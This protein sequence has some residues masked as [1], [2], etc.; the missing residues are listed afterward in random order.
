M[1]Q[2]KRICKVQ[3]E[4]SE[5]AIW[6]LTIWF[7]ASKWWWISISR[8]GFSGLI[9]PDAQC[10]GYLPAFT[11]KTTQMYV[12]RPYIDGIDNTKIKTRNKSMLRG[13]HDPEPS[14][15][16]SAPAKWLSL[17]TRKS[18]TYPIGS[19]GLVLFTYI[20]HQNQLN[21]G[22][23]TIHGWYGYGKKTYII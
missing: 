22:K 16:F 18:S 13:N 2:K 10:M 21:V 20:Y 12:N 9:C 8:T 11:P 6:H 7:I 4:L 3:T 14:K 17:V 1:S 5:I 19:M 23:H 15:R